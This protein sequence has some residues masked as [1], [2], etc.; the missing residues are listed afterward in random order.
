MKWKT[1][2]GFIIVTLKSFFKD[3]AIIF[4]TV[5][6]P[7]MFV[8]LSAYVFIPPSAGQQITLD[9]GVVN[10]DTS[11]TPFNGS[12]LVE[13]LEQAEY[14][15]RRLFNVKIYDN[16]TALIRDLENGKL[17]GGI[18]I[19]EDFGKNISV[20][21]ARLIVYVGG[22]SITSI[23]INRGILVG[24]IAEFS[25]RFALTKVNITLNMM[26]KHFNQ[27]WFYIPIND[28]SFN[29][30]E[31][32]R[33]YYTGLA[34]PV[35]ATVEEKVPRVLSN[36]SN[37]LGWYVIGALG[38]TFLYT[39]FSLGA[40]F[41]TTEKERGRLERILSSPATEADLLMG[42]L[43]A[44]II[45]FLIVSLIINVTGLILGAHILWD[46]LNPVHWLIPLNLVLLAMMTISIGFFLSLISKTTSGASS[47]GVALGIFLSFTAG[48]WFPIKWLPEP[49]R[50]LAQ[51]FPPT[52]GIDAVRAI[53]VY[54]ASFDEAIL[55][56]MKVAV[57]T[58]IIFGLG[59]L[60]Y[61]KTLS[62]YTEM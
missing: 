15:G 23:Q 41:I 14:R 1:I 49:L 47:L 39:G 34:V 45:V 32:L 10:H 44:G 55:M 7:I 42:K 20:G 6:L 61:K 24:F 38:M 52:W 5:G 8:L 18:I 60:A 21:T 50:I 56:S 36:R 54:N 59:V 19:P 4:W 57:A 48:I 27:T 62:R 3:K 46:P 58:V 2:K 17:N 13:I 35:N 29:L 30:T 12:S 16:D 31:L 9:I 26:E 22:D 11:R 33:R 43:L 53:M 40:T 25:K 51:I 37:I 28:S